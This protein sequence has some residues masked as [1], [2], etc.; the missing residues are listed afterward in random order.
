M[1]VKA[2]SGSMELWAAACEPRSAIVIQP[3]LPA[4]FQPCHEILPDLERLFKGGKPHKMR[5]LARG[6][7]TSEDS[8][9]GEVKVPICVVHMW[10][11]SNMVRMADPF[12]TYAAVRT[13]NSN[14]PPAWIGKMAR[15]QRLVESLLPGSALL[16][17]WS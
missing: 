1:T 10:G 12:A 9:F 11:F 13:P 15:V 17:T 7:V 2:S 8:P 4:L 5:L 16:Y 3:K 14:P 6:L